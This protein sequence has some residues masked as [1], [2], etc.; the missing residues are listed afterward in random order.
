[1]SMLIGILYQKHESY[2]ETSI[3]ILKNNEHFANVNYNNYLYF[4]KTLFQKN[5]IRQNGYKW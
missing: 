1:M 2:Y 5:T 4:R 3:T